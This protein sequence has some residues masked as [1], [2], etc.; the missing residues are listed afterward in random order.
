MMDNKEHQYLQ[1]PSVLRSKLVSCEIQF[2][3]NIEYEYDPILA[4][5]CIDRNAEDQ[6]KIS[7]KDF[8][9]YIEISIASGKPIR[10]R[11]GQI[12]DPDKDVGYYGVSLFKK[13]EIVENQMHLPRP[14]KKICS[15]HVYM[16]GGPQ[17]TDAEHINWWMHE[18][19]D[20]S[21]FRIE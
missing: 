4:Y 17:A 16:E 12:T 8:L 11:K 5:R 14:S 6:T 3:E 13:K 20:L 2:P 21:G 18:D 10:K 9:S 7:R 19:V 1:F 15:G